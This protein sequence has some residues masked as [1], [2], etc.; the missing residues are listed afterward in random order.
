MAKRCQVSF[1]FS[2]RTDP[3]YL[4]RRIE[5]ATRIAMRAAELLEGTK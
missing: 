2:E 5:T 4:A 3:D 1:D